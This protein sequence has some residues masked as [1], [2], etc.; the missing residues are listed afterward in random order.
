MG[1]TGDHPVHEKNK[2]PVY[3][4][5][6]CDPSSIMQLIRLFCNSEDPRI[7]N[8]STAIPVCEKTHSLQT[9]I[10]TRVSCEY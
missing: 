9:R 2:A 3:M 10:V 6:G 7:E 1:Y 5:C 4:T 8:T